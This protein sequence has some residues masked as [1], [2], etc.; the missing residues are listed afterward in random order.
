M[1]R[2]RQ[3]AV[4]GGGWAGLAAAVEATRRGHHVTLFEMAPQL[5][6]RARAVDFGEALLDN[7]QHILIGAYAQTLALMRFVGVDVDSAL[8]RT[9][10]RVTYP[11]GAGLQLA[12]GSPLVTFAAAVMRYPGWGWRE[13][14]AM[15]MASA[16][17]AL[18]RFRCDG[19]LTVAQLTAHLPAK[20][21][22]ELLDP[23]CVAALNTP[24]PQASAAVFLRVLK[25]ALFS[26]P[27]SADLLLPRWRLSE[28]WP[29]PAARWLKASGATLRLSTRVERLAAGSAGGWLLD[30]QPFDT[31]VLA[32]TANE[33]ARLAHAIAPAWSA[34][35]AGLRYEPIVT[36]YA[37]QTRPQR[38]P[39]PMTALRSDAE[40]PAQFAFD[41]GSLGGPDGV[42]ALV[43]SGAAQW[44]ARGMAATEHAALRQAE[45][46]F[47]GEPLQA[48]R[49]TTEKRATF[50]CTP[51][52]CRPPQ[53]LLPGLLAAGDY[54]EGPYP[55]TLEGAIRS[56]LAAGK[57]A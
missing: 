54:V 51:G 56:G 45:S 2:A 21:R 37:R 29:A 36:V 10:L 18:Q 12:P 8:L 19:S 35:A 31:V 55:A 34:Q 9:P 27:G 25:D 24:A 17:W 16:R 41:L 4:V 42:L 39:Q 38:L 33:A 47:G 44:V 23:L 46:A 53:Q 13:K 15:L 48:L 43:I 6:G 32:C 26:G 7:G 14:R 5:G 22:D 40:R 50:L 52:L 11:D 28:L 30:D 1:A 57:V 3:V 49:T 20:V